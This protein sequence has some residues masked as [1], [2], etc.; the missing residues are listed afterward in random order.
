MRTTEV[1]ESHLQSPKP[2]YYRLPSVVQPNWR[3]GDL[4]ATLRGDP[5]VRL[6]REL[7]TRYHARY[8]LLLDRARSGLYLL[9]RAY[10]LNDEWILT[11]LM[12]RPS[13]VLLKEYCEGLALADVD[14]DFG[15]KPD[16]VRSLLSQSTCAVLATHLYGKAADLSGLRRLADTR[17]LVLVENAVHMAGGCDSNGR[18]IGSWGDA[19]LL[20]FNLDKPLGS[21]LGGALLTSREDIWQA[22]MRYALGPANGRETRERIL[23]T[24]LAYRLKGLVLRLPRARRHR[25]ASDGVAEI[26]AF[27]TDRY[28]TYVPRRI[29]RLQAGVALRC[30]LREDDIVARRRRNAEHLTRE[31][32]DVTQLI[33]PETSAHRPHV[34]TYYPIVLKEGSRYQLGV[35]L[36][37]A[38]IET[39]WRYYPLHLQPGFT[40]LR[41]D[42]M[43]HTEWL[44][45]Q[46]LLLPAGAAT[47]PEQIDYL[48]KSLR[49]TLA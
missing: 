37:A 34:Y 25:G 38:G 19:T 5:F 41:R 7:C 22:V 47:S 8:C 6:N 23:T 27:G 28:Q 44:W 14:D 10:G 17:G 12:H 48:A 42:E 39:K 26:E 32:Q 20:S 4:L 24:Y 40:D 36:A 15:I 29:H 45:K 18:R 33:L 2:Q 3:P 9:C 21:I 30:V 49:K 46:H 31:L 35:R 1:P 43:Q 16:S 11:S 13:A